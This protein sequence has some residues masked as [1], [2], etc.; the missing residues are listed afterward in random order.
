M[1]IHHKSFFSMWSQSTNALW[2][3]GPL[4][5]EQGTDFIIGSPVP[6]SHTIVTEEAESLGLLVTCITS[7]AL[8]SFKST[9]INKGFIDS[10]GSKYFQQGNGAAE[11]FSRGNHNN[12]TLLKRATSLTNL[13]DNDESY[14]DIDSKDGNNKMKEA[15]GLGYIWP[16]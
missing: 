10:Q 5:L 6:D 7:I 3:I 8:I 11:A 2:G 14:I 4:G 15:A 9:L 13:T 12:A 16:L 1:H